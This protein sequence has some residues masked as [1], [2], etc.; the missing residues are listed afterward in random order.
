[1]RIRAKQE[2]REEK[3]TCGACEKGEK[4]INGAVEDKDKKTKTQSCAVWRVEGTCAWAVTLW[5][6]DARSSY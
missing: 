2:K 1:M 6:K 3:K 4:K 5:G